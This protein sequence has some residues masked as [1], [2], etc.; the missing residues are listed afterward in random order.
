MLKNI[1][2]RKK[3]VAC[4]EYIARQINDESIFDSWLYVGVADGDIPY[5]DL[6]TENVSDYY[7]EDDNF[8]DLMSCFLRRMKRAYKSG[9]LYCGGVVSQ[10]EGDVENGNY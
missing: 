6:S 7:V 5:G 4:M 2:A 1:E 3:M 8:R 9:G 10:T